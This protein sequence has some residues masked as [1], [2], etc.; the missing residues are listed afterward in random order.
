MNRV[1]NIQNA[2]PLELP[3]RRGVGIALINRQGLLWT[4]RR[5][6]KWVGDKS[7]YIWQ[8][9]QGG[10]DPGEDPEEAAYRELEEETGVQSAEIIA[11]H[12]RWLSYDLPEDLLGIALK[13]RY[14]GQEQRWFAMRFLGD[15][16]E[17]NVAPRNGRKAEFDR[18]KWRPADEVAGLAVSFKRS[19]YEEIVLSF[20]QFL[21]PETL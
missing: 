13:G 2:Q 16:A 7:A 19:M 10:I 6:P 9:P 21:R 5:S 11:E 8:M 3:Y 15:D 20:A 4:G 1:A 17:I 12:P 18:W 14:R